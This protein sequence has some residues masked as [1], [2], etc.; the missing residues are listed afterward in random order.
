MDASENFFNYLCEHHV[1]LKCTNLSK[2][3]YVRH[4]EGNVVKTK[5]PAQ[6]LPDFATTEGHEHDAPKWQ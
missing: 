2:R 1:E 5:K 4:T 6:P 3:F